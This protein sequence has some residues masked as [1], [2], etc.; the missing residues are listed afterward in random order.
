VIHKA[1]HFR[2]TGRAS[3]KKWR[4]YSLFAV[5]V[6]AIAMTLQFA[7]R[8][9]FFYPLVISTDSM[10]PAIMAG[11]K[12]YFLYARLGRI[13]KDDI[14]LVKSKNTEVDYFCRVIGVD[15]DK[16]KIDKGTLNINSEARR[17]LKPKLIIEQDLSY[18]LNEVEIR[19]NHFFCMNDNAANTSDSRLHGI[20]DRA[21]IKAK[22]IRPTLFF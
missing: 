12:H 16:I 10:S 4:R 2:P 20:F 7:F 13:R 9:L 14:V 19:P 3:H 1:E 17:L 22:L 21:Q 8:Q 6:F 18:H 15:G 5:V 11:Q